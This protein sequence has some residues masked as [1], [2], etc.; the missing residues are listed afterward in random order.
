MLGLVIGFL[1]FYL[2]RERRRGGAS[3]RQSRARVDLNGEAEKPLGDPTTTLPTM[4]A[5]GPGSPQQMMMGASPG[6]QLSYEYNP[7]AEY[8]TSSSQQMLYN[9]SNPQMPV[10]MTVSPSNSG[11]LATAAPLPG[12]GAQPSVVPIR[13]FPGIPSGAI[14]TVEEQLTEKRRR[15]TEDRQRRRQNSEN[16]SM[17][18]VMSPSGAVSPVDGEPGDVTGMRRSRRSDSA[19]TSLDKP[20]AGAGD[21][22]RA[23]KTPKRVWLNHQHSPGDAMSD[24]SHDDGD[25]GDQNAS[26]RTQGRR[27]VEQILSTPGARQATQRDREAPPPMYVRS[28]ANPSVPRPSV[29][30]EQ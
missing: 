20:T 28:T 29:A 16:N 1:V 18:S 30:N 23:E 26:H 3:G 8:S 2:M 14:P 10:T 4:T 13:A 25:D 24:T 7:Y 27:A 11:P 17:S 22:K 12:S 21:G 6:S 9:S 5:M 19:D 15:R